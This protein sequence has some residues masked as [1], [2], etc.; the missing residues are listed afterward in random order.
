MSKDNTDARRLELKQLNERAWAGEEVFKTSLKLDSSL[1]KNTGFIKKIKTCLNADQYRGALKDIESLS[2]GK[3]LSEVT[4]SVY[5]GLLKAAKS[6]DINASIEVVSALHQRFNEQFTLPLSSLILN[7]LVSKDQSDQTLKRVLLKILMELYL[8][9]MCSSLRQCERETLNDVALRMYKASEEACI[10]PVLKDIMSYQINSGNSLPII[11]SFLK[12]FSYMLD[13]NALIPSEVLTML[14]QIFLVYTKKVF[15]ILQILHNQVITMT[16]KNRKAFIRTGRILEEELQALIEKTELK[17]HF[18]TNA[19]SLSEALNIE[20]PV[21]EALSKNEPDSIVRPSSDEAELGGWDD[22][23]EKNF[24]TK[25]PTYEDVI[26]SYDTSKIRSSEYKNLTDGETIVHFLHYLE[27]AAT[28]DDL[29]KLIVEMHTFITYNKA[30]KNKILRFF[31]EVEKVDNVNLYARFLCISY[32]K[33]PDLITELIEVLDRGF[34]SQIHHNTINFK[35]LSFFIELVKFKL[36]P[37]HIVFHKIRRLTLNIAGTNNV[38]ILLIFYERCGKFLLH[39]PEYQET[40]KEMLELLSN[41]SKSDKLSVNVKLALRNMFYIVDSF[42]STKPKVVAPV[43]VLSPMQDFVSQ[44]I[45]RVLTPTKVTVAANLLG[46]INFANSQDAQETIVSLY[47]RPEELGVDKFDALVEVLKGLGN[48]SKYVIVRIVDLLVE[49]V[50]RGLELNDYR[51]NTARTAQ[52][53][54]LATFFNRKVLSFKC[55]L[56]LLY[57]IVCLGHPGNTPHPGSQLEVDP[58]DNYFRIHLCCTLLKS[59]Q[60]DRVAKAK[61]L[62]GGVK[63]VEGFLLFFQYYIAC[64]QAPLPVEL[65]F[66]ILDVLTAFESQ[67]GKSFARAED[68]RSAV[69]DLQQFNVKYGQ[70]EIKGGGATESNDDSDSDSSDSE[71]DQIFDDDDEDED[72]L[73]DK[74]DAMLIDEGDEDEDDEEDE[75]EE[76]DEEEDDEEETESDMLDGEYLSEEEETWNS[77]D[78]VKAELNR[79]FTQSIDN[80]FNEIVNDSMKIGKNQVKTALKVP[81]PSTIIT[82][83]G[84]TT[85]QMK[86]SFLSRKNELR[87]MALP[88]GNQFADRVMREQEAQKANRAKIMS[89]VNNMES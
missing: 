25:V 31:L 84:A 65:E 59:V 8:V 67:N 75:D 16:E 61:L 1:K 60:L 43:I 51:Q 14:K 20:M 26:K 19:Q 3:Y 47:L 18:M 54:F 74:L 24:Y 73:E 41:M 2:L 55:L 9:G 79:K 89:L 80:G 52:V 15:E 57:K 83:N 46:K 58:V 11:V 6:D 85:G 22:L 50:I 63:T 39:D 64:K 4:G 17:Q 49:K 5:E 30:T 71:N 48:H 69:M 88:S 44:V 81:A 34:R 29:D 78:A 10:V 86:F 36:I 76:D 53:K 62:T 72:A 45:R 21:L 66:S 27:S 56:D 77:E 35:N 13:G 37:S 32:E 42:T 87:E 12:R 23:K 28:E 70:S 7:A 33:F 38:D 40:T 68:L 82:S